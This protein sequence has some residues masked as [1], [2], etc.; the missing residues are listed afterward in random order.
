MSACAPFIPSPVGLI[1][2]ATHRAPPAPTASWPRK[3]LTAHR[4]WRH[5]S[6]TASRR[7]APAR[8]SSRRSCP[9]GTSRGRRWSHCH[10]VAKLRSHWGGANAST[11]NQKSFLKQRK[12]VMNSITTMLHCTPACTPASPQLPLLAAAAQR[13]IIGDARRRNAARRTTAGWYCVAEAILGE[14]WR[15]WLSREVAR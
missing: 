7:G 11:K 1:A 8:C 13:I 2:H 5:R 15:L 12:I 6:N 10:P 3:P 4:T 14:V 9:P